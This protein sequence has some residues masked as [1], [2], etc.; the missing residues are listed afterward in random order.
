MQPFDDAGDFDRG[1][2][3]SDVLQVMVEATRLAVT[4]AT[5]SDR[6]KIGHVLLALWPTL[7]SHPRW[8]SAAQQGLGSG[9]TLETVPELLA[10]YLSDSRT[11]HFFELNRKDFEPEVLRALEGCDRVENDLGDVVWQADDQPVG[12]LPLWVAILGNPMAAD[13]QGCGRLFDFERAAEAF[14][15]LLSGTATGPVL[16][17]LYETDGNLR[18]ECFSD[19]AFE[20]LEAARDQASRIGY[21]VLRP[22]HLVLAFLQRPDG[23]LEEIIRSQAR[24]DL[25]PQSIAE[26]LRQRMAGGA[27]AERLALSLNRMEFSASLQALLRDAQEIAAR[28][29]APLVAE[30]M[31]LRAAL[32]SE[33]DGVAGRTLVEPPVRLNFEM[34]LRDTDRRILD[35][36]HGQA[37]DRAAPIHLAVGMLKTEDL[38]YLARQSRQPRSI[39]QET[40]IE[41]VQRG[42]FRRQNNSILITGQSGVGKTELVRE[43][44]R[45]IAAGDIPFLARKKIVRVDGQQVSVE[46]SRQRVRELL[47]AVRGR[48][49]VIP[50]LDH[51]EH[52][53]KYAGTR[54]SD[55][56][57]L[58]RLA[59]QEGQ[60]QILAV[61]EDRY[62]TQLISHDHALLDLFTRVEVLELDAGQTVEVLATSTARYLEELYGVKIERDVLG[63]AAHA[64]REFIMSERLPSKAIR[65]VRDA[66]E[67]VSYELA[68]NPEREAVVRADDLVWAISER[69][70]I[71]ASTISGSGSRMDFRGEL[72]KSVVGQ[73]Q[74][75]QV[76]ADRLMRIKAG[77]VQDNKPAAVFLFAGLTGTGKTELAKAIARLYSASRKLSMYPM[78]NFTEA[79]SISGLLGVPPGYVGFESGGRLV[80]DLNAD[81]YGVILFDEAE[82]AHPDVWQSM[83]TLFD[84]AWAEDRRNVRAYGNCAVFVLTSNA[85]QE[86][87]RDNYQRLPPESLKDHVAQFLVDY[88]HPTTGQR[89]FPPEFLARFTDIVIF[90][91]LSA[92]AM[93]EITQIHLVGMIADWRRKQRKILLVDGHVASHIA[94]LAHRENQ[95]HRSTKGGRLIARYVSDLIELPLLNL[96]QASP[97][98]FRDA[99]KVHVTLQDEKIVVHLAEQ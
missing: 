19:V 51:F 16:A 44:A 81:P 96:M 48:S 68:A 31:L 79:H 5:R 47:A 43:L 11:E 41:K 49:D 14:V 83:L 64:S 46:D 84:E 92:D 33:A 82:K 75:V 35:Y 70:G 6:C 10:S 71:D 54:E 40:L 67:R 37:E 55:N 27:S 28:H 89:P 61:I 21:N 65:S 1:K 38:T 90:N 59:M 26:R 63:R 95:Q 42:L 69:T 56:R 30:P 85:G 87:I 88:Q 15:R 36:R 97:D 2:F 86:F 94:A 12:V 22:A 13:R 72:A 45:R 34:L 60:L 93:R 20:I 52:F 7:G 4:P 32:S 77:V 23:L 99:D 53:L 76:V 25:D 24:I 58:F 74:A 98:A 78:S 80:N 8:S 3:T 73:Q 17:D 9:C 57:G 62:F 91:P 29:A 50:C 66:C 18:G 39:A